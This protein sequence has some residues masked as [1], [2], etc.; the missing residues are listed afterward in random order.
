MNYITIIPFYNIVCCIYP[1]QYDNYLLLD[2]ILIDIT[3][4]IYIYQMCEDTNKYIFLTN[5][6]Y[7]C[8]Y[9]YIE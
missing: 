1:K 9:I 8:I 3:S 6:I 4:A 7:C 2:A 5:K